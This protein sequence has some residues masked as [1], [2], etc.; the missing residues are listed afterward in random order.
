LSKASTR[1]GK[2]G[3]V[4]GLLGKEKKEKDVLLFLLLL[5]GKGRGTPSF[6]GGETKK[7]KKNSVGHSHLLSRGSKERGEEKKE[8]SA[9]FYNEHG[10]EKGGILFHHLRGET[11]NFKF[12]KFER[13]RRG[14]RRLPPSMPERGRKGGVSGKKEGV[15]ALTSK[16]SFMIRRFGGEGGRRRKGVAQQS[17][18]V[19]GEGREF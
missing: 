5:Q 9:V 17:I 19:W 14:N 16:T 8:K 1:R 12:K 10:K 15:A 13:K 7:K 3:D 2:G 11:G 18:H 4:Q 6:S